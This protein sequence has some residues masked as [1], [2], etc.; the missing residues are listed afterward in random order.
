MKRGRGAGEETCTLAT[1]YSWRAGVGIAN[2]ERWV[3]AV[4]LARAHWHLESIC[5]MPKQRRGQKEVTPNARMRK[6]IVRKKGKGSL[7]HGIDDVA[8]SVTG[9]Q[10]RLDMKP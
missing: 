8:G 1:L 2:T 5:N 9:V 7:R 3:H 6:S 4:S 10:Q